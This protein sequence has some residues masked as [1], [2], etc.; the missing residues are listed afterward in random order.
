MEDR[1]GSR[2]LADAADRDTLVAG[3]SKITKFKRESE[4][5][6]LLRSKLADALNG[7]IDGVILVTEYTNNVVTDD[8]AGMFSDSRVNRYVWRGILEDYC[9]YFQDIDVEVHDYD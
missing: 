2:Y 5:V 3:L 8:L 4:V 1:C 6:R 7:E 9:R